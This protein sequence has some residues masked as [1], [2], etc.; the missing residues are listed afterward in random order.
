MND[1]SSINHPLSKTTSSP[2]I[3]GKPGKPGKPPSLVR[4]PGT[5]QHHG[6]SLHAIRSFMGLWLVGGFFL[7]LSGKSSADFRPKPR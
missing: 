2:P 3:T 4:L 7:S 1:T 6:S 5:R